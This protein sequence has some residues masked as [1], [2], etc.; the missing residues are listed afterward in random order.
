MKEIFNNNYQFATKWHEIYTDNGNLYVFDYI[1][2]QL[3]AVYKAKD[4]EENR[5]GDYT[6]FDKADVFELTR[7]NVSQIVGKRVR[8]W[9]DGYNRQ[10]TGTA[11]ILGVDLNKRFVLTVDEVEGDDISYAFVGQFGFITYGDS[12][13]TITVEVL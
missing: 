12:D 4:T 11:R 9:S 10:E 3:D 5:C 6:G 13:R 2:G 1:D 7:D 8:F